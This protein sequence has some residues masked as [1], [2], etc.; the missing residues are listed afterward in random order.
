M[1]T[2]TVHEPLTGFKDDMDRYVQTSFIPEAKSL[3]ALVLPLPWLLWNR[4]W[5][6][7]L[8]YLLISTI[9]S[10]AL[11]TDFST[12]AFI[13]TAFPGIFLFLEGNDLRRKTLMRDGWA[14]VGSV[15]GDDL[16]SAEV[17]YFHSLEY[18]QPGAEPEPAPA[19]RFQGNTDIDTGIDFLAGPEAG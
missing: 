6:A 4:M 15:E 1:T 8:V 16:Q 12:L 3:A 11:T 18:R 19:K 9:L 7:A 17:R 2:Y 5:W 10:I 13:L 14:F